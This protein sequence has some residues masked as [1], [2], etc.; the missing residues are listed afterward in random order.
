MIIVKFCS[1]IGNQL[2]QYCIYLGLKKQ[3]PQ[4]PIKADLT[5][6]KNDEILNK[7][8]GF[9][10]GF[11]LTKFF[12]I[13]IEEATLKETKNVNY[14]IV[15]NR[16]WIKYLPYIVRKCNGVSNLAKIRAKVFIKYKEMR[17][18][19]I[20]NKPFN[21]YNGNIYC[22]DISND[23]YIDG[24]WQNYKYI[25][26]VKEELRELI[27]LSTEMTAVLEEIL[28]LMQTSESVCIH[29]RRGN[30][31][32]PENTYSHDLCDLD[33]YKMGI[34]YI[35]RKVKTPYYFIFSDDISFC[36][37]LFDDRINKAIYVSDIEGINTKQEMKLMGQCKNAIISNSTFAFWAVWLGDNDEKNIVYPEYMVRNRESW[38][39]FSAPKSWYKIENL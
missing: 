8:N 38:A 6:F 24:L 36:K 21:S 23:Y 17:K 31:T 12:G 3:Y 2:Y 25:E 20:T 28:S 15:F 9:A 18:N 4:I 29:V 13:N 7:G 32:K 33:Y 37:K 22:L 35:E 34:E 11:G 39:E 5:A 14:G 1:G 26:K 10:Y 16:F 19:Y 30:F 27:K